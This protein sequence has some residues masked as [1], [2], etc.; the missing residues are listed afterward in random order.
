M[1]V[2]VAAHVVHP[3]AERAVRGEERGV[4]LLGAEVGEIALDHHRVGI[5]RA[6]SATTARFMISG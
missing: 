2:V 4:L 6:I 3:V 1:R 5:E